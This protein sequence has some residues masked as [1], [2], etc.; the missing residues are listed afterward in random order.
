MKFFLLDDDS[1]VRN[2]LKIIIRDRGL[3]EL[4]GSYSS[5]KE[6]LEDLPS[7]AIDIVIVDL[8]MPEMDGITFVK[9]A[10]QLQP[11]LVF[12]MLSQVASKDMISSAYEGGIDF[13]IQKPINSIE[14]EAVLRRTVEHLDMKRKMT[15]VQSFF[16]NKA[17]VTSTSFE[18]PMAESTTSISIAK[19]KNVLQKLGI[20]GDTGSKDILHV[21]EYLLQHDGRAE[22]AT[23]ADIC[24]HFNENPKSVEQRMRRAA[25]AGLINLAHLGLEDYSNDIFSE[26]ST[27]LFNFEQVRTEMDYIRKRGSKHGNVKVKNFLNAL[28]L[29]CQD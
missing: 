28:K 1:N 9:K 5:G 12:V 19:A 2:I 18:P 8:L 23:L 20:S 29:Y 21:M 10:K 22:E 4:C 14:V 13:F 17:T 7:L 25:L 26:F 24:S 15:Q 11:E 16:T 6:A 27:K 3:G